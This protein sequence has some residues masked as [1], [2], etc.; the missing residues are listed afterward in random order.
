MD[1]GSSLYSLVWS[2]PYLLLVPV[3]VLMSPLCIISSSLF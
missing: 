1:L 2:V 3:W